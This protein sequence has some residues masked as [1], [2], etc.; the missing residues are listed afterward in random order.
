M[1]WGGG[2]ANASTGQR[3]ETLL[4]LLQCLGKLPIT[5]NCPVQNV[6]SAKVG[7]LRIRVIFSLLFQNFMTFLNTG[8][9]QRYFGLSS[10][11]P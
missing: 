6:S 9:A 8:I 7:K 4:I 1:G 5:N 3:P 10:R 2:D 11:A